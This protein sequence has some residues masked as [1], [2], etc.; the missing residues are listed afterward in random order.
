[1]SVQEQI[2]RI[3][4]LRDR[5]F[6][7][8][9]PLVNSGDAEFVKVM[10]PENSMVQQ[11]DYWGDDYITLSHDD[12]VYTSEP[13]SMD[14]TTTFHT[15]GVS[16]HIRIISVL[17][18]DLEN[19]VIYCSNTKSN[20]KEGDIIPCGNYEFTLSIGDGI[21]PIIVFEFVKQRSMENTMESIANELDGVDYY[22]SADVSNPIHGMYVNCNTASG[23]KLIL[24]TNW[25]DYYGDGDED[26]PIIDGY[27]NYPMT[28]YYAINQDITDDTIPE[29]LDSVNYKYKGDNCRAILSV[30]VGGYVSVAVPYEYGWA[31]LD[32][33]TGCQCEEVDSVYW[34]DD[35]GQYTVY[36]I[37][38][39]DEVAQVTFDYGE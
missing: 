2:N 13:L 27:G 12:G 36:K 39:I 15:A 33:A 21:E 38:D 28:M 16:E 32:T 20:I 37:T 29:I 26:I 8:V 6:Q 24:C 31:D 25:G 22:E 3:K 17:D 5:V 4:G 9:S 35:W 1:M 18:I 7:K 11:Y 14:Q 19:E 23:A 10:P 34:G 30:P